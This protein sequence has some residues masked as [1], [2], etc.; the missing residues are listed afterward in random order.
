MTQ[1]KVMEGGEN[2]KRS[3]V[4]AILIGGFVAMIALPAASLAGQGYGRMKGDAKTEEQDGARKQL[5][6]RD[7]YCGNAAMG[8][9]GA[10]KKKGNTYGP[11]DGTG[12][13]GV[14]PRDGTGNGPGY[15]ARQNR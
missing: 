3:M 9:A 1:T 13:R 2:M 4:T 8:N 14:C 6:L 7:G 5:R 10:M 15:C 11:G 12:N